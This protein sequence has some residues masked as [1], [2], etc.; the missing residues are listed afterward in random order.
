MRLSTWGRYRVTRDPN[1]L[2]CR[3]QEKHRW[4]YSLF[5][6]F[7]VSTGAWAWHCEHEDYCMSCGKILGGGTTVGRRC[8][9]FHEH[10]A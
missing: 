1:Y 4:E 5:E 7:W 2:S 10:D 6:A 9:D 8:P 3:W